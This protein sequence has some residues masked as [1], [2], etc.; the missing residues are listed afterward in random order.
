MTSL[1]EEADGQPPLEDW[2][3]AVH[4]RDAL[5]ERASTMFEQEIREAGIRLAD[6]IGE[7]HVSPSQSDRIR[8][9]LPK[10]Q[11]AR[12][13]TAYLSQMVT[14]TNGFSPLTTVG[15]ASFEPTSVDVQKKEGEN[16]SICRISQAVAAGIV[17]HLAKDEEFSS[18]FTYE[19]NP[20]IRFE[21]GK[22]SYI[23]S[24]YVM[25]NGFSWRQDQSVRRTLSTEHIKELYRLQSGTYKDIMRQLSQRSDLF[26]QYL[27][28]QWLRP[29]FPY[30][31][32]DRHA[33]I[34]IYAML[35]SSGS[36]RGRR[37]ARLIRVI[38][39]C[40][41]K[42]GGSNPTRRIAL[43]MSIQKA[44]T[45]I[46]RLL[47]QRVPDYLQKG[48]LV[49]QDV[50][51][52]DPVAPLGNHVKQDLLQLGERMR[53]YLFRSHAYDLLVDHF[54]ERYGAGGICYDLEDFLNSFD[55]RKDRTRLM[56]Q[57][58]AND[59]KM[60][61]EMDERRIFSPASDSA[62]P[63]STAV[64][65]QLAA[66]TGIEGI[67]NG[68]YTMVV[69][70]LTPG[71]GGFFPRFFTLFDKQHG[72]LP[73]KLQKWLRSMYPEA[74]IVD[75]PANADFSS[76]QIDY[77]ITKQAL[78]WPGENPT[79]EPIP[80]LR[81]QDVSVIHTEENTLTLIGRDGRP[82][83]PQYLG[84]VPYR[85]LQGAISHF[86]TFI[87]PWV[88]A[89]PNLMMDLDAA[90]PEQIQ[91][92]PRKQQGRLVLR[93]ARWRIPIHLFPRKELRETDFSYFRR[94]RKWQ[95]ANGIPEEV[96]ISGEF[97]RDRLEAK[98]RKSMWMS[99]ESYHSL[100]A[101]IPSV[102]Q[103]DVNCVSLTEALPKL[104]DHWFV[105]SDGLR[106]ATQCSALLSWPRTKT[107]VLSTTGSCVEQV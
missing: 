56:R 83:A 61:T 23:R 39:A 67:R 81:L 86:F 82:I 89:F 9:W 65:F 68:D 59:M 93:R 40:E 34:T 6:Q 79:L 90:A 22:V 64:F 69:N 26:R 4:S 42:M 36:K 48:H 98:K 15:L 78:R 77:G 27:N 53:P 107:M 91:F 62:A 94:L 58:H 12:V 52:Q 97:G 63:P 10:N 102:I 29:I 50:R 46:F 32:K 84:T 70:Q 80:D 31:R 44:I 33:L 60:M 57:A 104:A 18:L 38:A 103:D 49:Y 51:V 95:R 101:A 1:L 88:N 55:R 37:I 72:N 35:K 75:F 99:F 87:V 45:S 43:Q 74:W 20:S 7:E 17:F 11:Y 71:L 105:G 66:A 41:E 100:E 76:L 47:N 5:I 13:S 21:Y 54:V 92:Y 8:K 14:K 16:R 3:E 2:L 106:Y 19:K 96:Y 30:S 24:H 28:E 73:A 25:V 85:H